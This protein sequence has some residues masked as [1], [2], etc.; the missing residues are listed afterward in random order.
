MRDGEP[1]APPHG[2][3]TLAALVDQ[4]GAAAT[5]QVATRAHARVRQAVAAGVRPPG[6][7]HLSD[8]LTAVEAVARP[9]SGPWPVSARLW[10]RCP[11]TRCS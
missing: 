10:R 7:R 8:R 5:D 6:L 3:D 9:D 4:L 11:T 2:G 1:D